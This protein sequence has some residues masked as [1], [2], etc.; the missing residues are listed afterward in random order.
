[1]I[2]LNSNNLL[3]DIFEFPFKHVEELEKI[4]KYYTVV[5]NKGIHKVH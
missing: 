4:L 1:M 3:R 5:V 2:S